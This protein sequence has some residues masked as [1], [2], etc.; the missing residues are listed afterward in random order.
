M[1][2]SSTVDF[3]CGLDPTFTVI[4]DEDDP[5]KHY[6]GCGFTKDQCT[7][8]PCCDDISNGISLGSPLTLEEI[9]SCFITNMK[10]RGQCCE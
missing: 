7:S 9:R 8:E 2:N 5:T 6:D 1:G 10:A 3:Y 4:H